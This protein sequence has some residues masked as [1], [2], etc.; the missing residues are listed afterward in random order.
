MLKFI[1]KRLLAIIPVV[2]GV[3]FIVFSV[4]RMAPGDPAMAALGNRYTEEQY[5]AKKAELGLDRP[6]L[7]QFAD[8]VVG[9]VTRFDLGTSY[10]SNRSVNV[11]I[12]ERLPVTLRLG[13]SGILLTV[14]LGVPLGIL[15]AVKQYSIGDYIATVLSLILAS[16][17]SFWL[18]LMLI[19]VFALHLQW[20]PASMPSIASAT[21]K[22]WILP[23]LTIGLPPVASV[24]RFTRSTMLDVIRQDYIR[25]ARAKGLS[26]RTV[27]FK[28]ALRNALLSIVTF[29]G[30][31]LGGTVAGSVVIES[32]FSVPGIG[33]LVTTAVSNQDYPVIQG[34]VLILSVLICLINLAVD[35]LYG[36]IDPRIMSMYKSDNKKR[37]KAKDLTTEVQE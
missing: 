28:H 9:V 19:I 26:E 23:V 21:I 6:F 35:V 25:T 13:L 32:I 15:A 11:E 14:A 7:V 27:I 34:C 24:L 31:M 10:K 16:M 18:G 22:H 20:L 8:Y 30:I 12:L 1:I 2:I 5:E 4:M 33:S 37:K 3:L 17:P 36:F 29:V